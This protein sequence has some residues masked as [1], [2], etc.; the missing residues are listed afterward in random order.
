MVQSL[1]VGD[2]GA[3]QALLDA[4]ECTCPN[5]MIWKGVFDARGEWYRVPDWVVLEP[6]GIAAEADIEAGRGKGKEAIVE[7]D[8][9]GEEELGEKVKVRCR[10]SSD[11]RDVVVGIHKRERVSGLI[12]N[13]KAKAKVSPPGFV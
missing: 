5:G 12:A 11:G 6:E 1:Q 3:A 8:G 9:D 2:V 7:T 13:L 10:L 4:I